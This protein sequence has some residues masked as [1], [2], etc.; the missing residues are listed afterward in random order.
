MSS[1]LQFELDDTPLYN[2]AC[3][4]LQKL[5]DTC[6]PEGPTV[7][8]DAWCSSYA[9]A[10]KAIAAARACDEVAALLKAGRITNE[11]AV[12]LYTRQSRNFDP[13]RNAA[14]VRVYA[15]Q[16]IAASRGVRS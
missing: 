5:V 14:T 12:V 8:L 16:W 3:A 10:Q 9:D 15:E 4:K 2:S 6:T 13:E 1:Q 7:P 11:Q